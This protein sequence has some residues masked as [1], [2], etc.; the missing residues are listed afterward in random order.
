MN[1]LFNG[2]VLDRGSTPLCSI[3]NISLTVKHALYFVVIGS[4]PIYC[5]SL[6]SENKYVKENYKKMNKGELVQ[7]VADKT[8][9]TKKCAGDVVNSVTDII[10]S[11]LSEGESVVLPGFGTFSV[12]DRAAREGRNPLTGETIQIAASKSP[13]FKAGKSLKD[14]VNS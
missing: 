8:G 9:V 2:N 10:T 4:S 13:K 3:S 12:A 7:A 11:A 1:K 5:I 6:M 14:A